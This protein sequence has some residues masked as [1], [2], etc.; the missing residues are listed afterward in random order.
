MS[1][2]TPSTI[3][4][5]ICSSTLSI[6]KYSLTTPLTT[7]NLKQVLELFS[8]LTQ[9]PDD[10]DS[11]ASSLPIT[12]RLD[13]DKPVVI[14]IATPAKLVPYTVDLSDY[15][16]MQ[17]SDSEVRLPVPQ[18]DPI[19]PTLT[20]HDALPASHS[21]KNQEDLPTAVS[22]G[23]KWKP[24]S[25]KKLNVPS[26]DETIYNMGTVSPHPGGLAEGPHVSHLIWKEDLKEPS[27][28]CSSDKE[29]HCKDPYPIP[30]V[31]YPAQEAADT[32]RG[33]PVTYSKPCPQDGQSH[34]PIL[35]GFILNIHPMYIPFKL[36]DDKKGREIPAKY[37]QLFLNS[38]NP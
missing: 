16:P 11:A 29:E 28:K 1:S 8:D 13:D 18:E 35:P 10:D 25:T 24:S 30:T 15:S 32:H 38:D 9:P 27:E 20:N 26:G 2:P 7:T 4:D 34:S 36:V 22:A 5:V 3:K 23:R 14:W 37:V 19:V 31:G 33:W 12:S 17:T 6:H 21:V